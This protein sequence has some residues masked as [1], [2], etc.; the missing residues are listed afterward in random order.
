LYAANSKI[1]EWY[2]IVHFTD[3]FFVIIEK[4]R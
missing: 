4:I 2:V 3:T 1:G